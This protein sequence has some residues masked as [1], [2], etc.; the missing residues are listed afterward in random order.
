MT[1][2]KDQGQ[3]STNIGVDAQ[4]NPHICYTP[5][6]LK[7]AHF[8]N[9]KWFS[10]MIDQGNGSRVEYECSVRVTRDGKPMLAWYWPD[11]G[12]RY[13]VLG[14][15]VWI[16]TGLD[17]SPNDYAGKW[18]SMVLDAN[19]NPQI[20]YSDFP[21]GQLRYAR[22]DGKAW[23]HS[24]LHSVNDDPGGPKGMGASIV[25]DAQGNPWISY[26]DEQSL[27][28]M[29]YNNGKWTKQTVEKIPPFGN[30]GWKQFRSDIAL[31]HNGNPHIV[32][33]S[34]QGLEH[35]W[36]DGKDW[37]S[38]IVLASSSIFDNTMVMDDKDSLYVVYKDPSDG[39]LKLATGRFTS[40][41]QS[42]NTSAADEKALKP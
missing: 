18:N 15:G 21:G 4:G 9:K 17:G 29:H 25:L 36:W 22:Y 12:F 7:Y 3:F 30:W 35:A 37:H 24:V 33:E 6:V 2:D 42:I 14:N 34:L 39:S 38:Q 8:D 26:Y 11:G 13:A 1:V 19:G 40:K 27:R 28:A 10:Q 41:L 32:F 31:D 5:Y 23:I 16:A 20:A